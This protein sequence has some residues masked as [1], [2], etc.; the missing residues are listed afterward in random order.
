MTRQVKARR[1]H[2]LS[3]SAFYRYL[4]SAE[5]EEGMEEGQATGMH[6]TGEAGT[7]GLHTSVLAAWQARKCWH[8]QHE[9]DDSLNLYYVNL[10][11][12]GSG[13]LS[14]TPCTPPLLLIPSVFIFIFCCIRPQAGRLAMLFQSK[15]AHMSSHVHHLSSHIKEKKKKKKE[16]KER[17]FGKT[18]LHHIN[19]TTPA[20][21]HSCEQKQKGRQVTSISNEEGRASRK[22]A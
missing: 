11:L 2:E 10:C 17:L 7:H 9:R 4:L 8:W 20:L 3:S 12:Y 16:E 19:T 22:W 1:R 21:S 14:L 13:T 6:R 18:H 15:A 5:G